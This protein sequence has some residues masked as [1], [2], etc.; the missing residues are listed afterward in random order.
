M[1]IAEETAAGEKATADITAMKKAAVE[2]VCDQI[3]AQYSE[4]AERMEVEQNPS[5]EESCVAAQDMV[6]SIV[7]SCRAD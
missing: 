5:R 2:K 6:R 7:L 3:P 1:Q 4:T